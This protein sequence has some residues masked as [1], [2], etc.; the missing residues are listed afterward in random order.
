MKSKTDLLFEL[1]DKPSFIITLFLALQ[2]ILLFL[3]GTVVLPVI[4][5]KAIGLN[6]ADM[7][8]L[9]FSSV[10]VSGIS[11]LIQV[12]KV[13]RVGVGH[14]LFMGSDSSYISSI[15]NAGMA[16]GL[17]L[18]SAMTILSAP[19]ELLLSYFMRY[20]RKIITPVIGG[21]VI[22][23]ISI[24]LLPLLM[25]LW[26]GMPGSP[27]YCSYQNL[28]TGCVT[29]G[30]ILLC[31]LLGN[32]HIQ[33][34]SPLFGLIAGIIVAIFFGIT[35]FTDLSEHDFFGFPNGK[36]ILPNFHFQLSHIPIFISFLF[37]TL[38]STIETIGDSITIQDSSVNNLK[39]INY[40]VVQGGLYAD[41]VSNILAGLLGTT[42]NTTFSGN[43][44]VVKLTRV[45]SRKVGIFASLIIIML[46]FFPKFIFLLTLIP[47]PVLGASSIVFMS[48]LLSS[49]IKLIASTKID[50]ELG[51]IIGVSLVVGIISNFELFFPLFVND[52]IKPFVNNG[53]ATGGLTA[54]ILSI[55]IKMKR[56][57]IIKVKLIN[58]LEDFTKL[59]DSIESVK[60]NF[61]MISKQYYNLQLCCEE[62][63]GYIC[64]AS[65]NLKGS[66]SFNFSEENEHIKVLV[67]NKSK[68][69]D[70]DL[71]DENEIAPQSL[72]LG[73]LVVNKLAK[74]VEHII[75]DG[76]NA[77][78]FVI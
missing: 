77:I 76:H 38:A 62:V 19:F 68:L 17:G 47:R 3:P 30:V 33:I 71:I 67:E 24:S 46:A 53:V 50:Y 6:S 5:A 11:S 8:R 43:I 35:N 9:V 54:I 41:A 20:V 7:E 29:I 42:P 78:S 61:E 51:V 73:L 37:A 66:I 16:G 72:E 28:L 21:I 27:D 31:T 45:A 40:E 65:E 32:K 23:L 69:K 48:L 18:I 36:W 22:I 14:M 60:M 70:I 10:F 34:W 2:H 26:T 15:I 59:Q 55:I 13:K 25:E 57:N 58:T 44:A 49:G 74:D 12:I 56:K 1:N 4:L 75:I 64:E 52:T 39:K 63:F